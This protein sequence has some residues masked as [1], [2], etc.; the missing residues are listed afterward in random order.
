MLYEPERPDMKYSRSQTESK[1]HAQPELAFEN[2]VLTSFAGLV[3]FQKFFT[4]MQLKKTLQACF[5]H[6]SG[7]K[8]F[9]RSTLFIQLILHLLLGYRELKDS[10]FYQDDPLVKRVL[11]LKRLPD[12]ATLSRFLKDADEKNVENL[13]LT[14]REMVLTRL[15]MIMP[16]RITLDF[17]GSV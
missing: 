11:G 9:G 6:M 15:R 3:I 14:L 16:A 1:V 17:D 13:R 7:G 12:V 4:A 2:Q 10:R 5:A 8:I